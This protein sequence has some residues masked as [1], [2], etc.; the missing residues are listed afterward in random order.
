VLLEVWERDPF[1]KL[2]R[3]TIREPVNRIILEVLISNHL[4]KM[5]PWAGR[6]NSH[7]AMRKR[8]DWPEGSN[9]K[10]LHVGLISSLVGSR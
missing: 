10:V 2:A 8:H 4:L 3:N 7:V 1:S 5:I 9:D 6:E